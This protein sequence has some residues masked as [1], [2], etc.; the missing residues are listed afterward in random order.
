VRFNLVGIPTRNRFDGEIRLDHL[1][2]VAGDHRATP[3]GI[4]WQRYDADAPYPDL[5]KTLPHVAFEV[6]DLAASLEGQGV[7]IAPNSP[8]P[9]VVAAFIEVSGAP[10]ELMQIDRAL[11]GED[12]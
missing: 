6:D 7:I 1:K 8:S 10:V 9:G 12:V 4:Q 3:F 5:V 2:M 11:A